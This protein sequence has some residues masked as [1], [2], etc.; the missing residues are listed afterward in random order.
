MLVWSVADSM[1]VRRIGGTWVIGATYGQI[2]LHNGVQVVGNRRGAIAAPSGG[3]TMDS[4]AR[5]AIG[6]I[7]AAM[8]AHGLIAS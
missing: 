1:P 8:R 2:L 7:L 3:G 4:E 6:A 5:T